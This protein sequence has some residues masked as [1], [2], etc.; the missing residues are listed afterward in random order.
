MPGPKDLFAQIKA[1]GDVGSGSGHGDAASA[2]GASPPSHN[3]HHHHHHHPNPNNHKQPHSPSPA[4]TAVVNPVAAMLAARGVAGGG[5]GL[6]GQQQQQPSPTNKYGGCGD[7]SKENSPVKPTRKTTDLKA[8]TKTGDGPFSYDAFL[9]S[10]LFFGTGD[11]PTTLG[12]PKMVDGNGG[13]GGDAGTNCDVVLV[14]L[15]PCAYRLTDHTFT[16][17]EPITVKRCVLKLGVL[18]C[19]QRER[20]NLNS[21]LQ[22]R[23]YHETLEED[24]LGKNRFMEL[25]SSCGV[26]QKVSELLLKRAGQVLDA[27]AATKKGD[28][29]NDGSKKDDKEPTV[30]IPQVQVD[31][32]DDFLAA[33]ERHCPEL[34]L[35]RKEIEDTQ[36]VSFYPGLGE[37]FCPGSKLVCKLFDDCGGQHAGA[38]PYLL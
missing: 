7:P 13:G 2:P 24:E 27:L 30:R 32:L 14:P 9:K 12:V 6:G 18:R 35:A 22:H 33:I 36:A 25:L 23:N 16:K 5:G 10:F 38:V 15:A 19:L 3:Q 28:G 11:T 8:P 17:R 1:R 34:E 26:Y 29:D 21:L 31:G 37:L 20:D 4:P